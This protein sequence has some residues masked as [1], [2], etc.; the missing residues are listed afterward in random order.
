MIRKRPRQW[1]ASLVLAAGMVAATMT[2]PT[3]AHASGAS[4]SPGPFVAT[5]WLSAEDP[6]TGAKSTSYP[7]WMTGNACVLYPDALVVI[8]K[9][10]SANNGWGA[11]HGTAY[12]NN[13]DGAR[14]M[15]GYFRILDGNGNQLATVSMNSARMPDR[16]VAYSFDYYQ[17]MFITPANFFFA[18]KVEW[19]VGC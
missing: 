11:L 6:E 13:H 4:I 10:D 15:I 8:S 12:R 14:T 17:P 5:T 9:P 19:Q 16:L 18:A 2:V 3:S 1:L 7:D